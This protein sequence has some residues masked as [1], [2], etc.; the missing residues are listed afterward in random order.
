[1]LEKTWSKRLVPGS[2]SSQLEVLRTTNFTVV[3]EDLLSCWW[4]K[5]GYYLL[6]TLLYYILVQ[7]FCWVLPGNIYFEHHTCTAVSSSS[8]C[9]MSTHTRIYLQCQHTHRSG[10]QTCCA[11][12]VVPWLYVHGAHT[13]HQCILAYIMTQHAQ[14]WS[15][16][17]KQCP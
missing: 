17:A 5:W 1:M 10:P 15:T 2:T 7:Q 11:I 8:T 6:W 12:A 3:T 16:D 9:H 13:T 14:Q 4:S